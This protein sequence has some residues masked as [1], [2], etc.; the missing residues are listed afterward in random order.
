VRRWLRFGNGSVLEEV[1][2][3]RSFEIGN[4][5]THGFGLGNAEGCGRGVSD[6]LKLWRSMVSWLRS[7]RG[8]F[9]CRLGFVRD[10]TRKK[11]FTQGRLE[12]GNEFLK[13]VRGWSGRSLAHGVLDNG[14]FG[15]QSRRSGRF[16]HGDGW[17]HRNCF[18]NR[19]G[20]IND[21]GSFVN[22][23]FGSGFNCGRFFRRG[24]VLR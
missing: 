17:L 24:G 18:D 13:H 12:V 23:E 2:P 15:A 11:A 22:F 20:F 4:E 14:R 5:L 21:R 8:V 10:S 16:G 19:R 6:G 3:Q 7:G 1:I 9:D